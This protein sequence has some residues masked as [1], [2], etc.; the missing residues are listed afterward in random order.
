VIRINL[1]PGGAT[2]RRAPTRGTGGGGPSIPKLPGDPRLAG[3]GGAAVLFLILAGFF[4]YSLGNKRTALAAQVER[5]TADSVRL[6][7]TISLMNQLQARRDTIERKI[8]VIRSVDGQRYTWPHLL[9]EISRSVPQYTWLTKISTTEEEE[10]APA[11]AGPA[12][13]DS[14]GVDSA[15]APAAPVAPAGP[16]FTLEGSTGSTQ[17]LTRLM[18]NLEAS[19]L[20]RDVA[21]VTSEQATQDRRTFLK[22]TLEAR[23]ETPD[24]SLIETVPVLT[25]P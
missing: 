6:A 10:A 12:P 4:W 11:A 24:S 16:A 23:F 21:L 17:A 20:I 3:L 13:A 14:A 22:F 5:E 18:K 8:D 15:S 25:A 7:R 19:P 9:D 1:L 2:T